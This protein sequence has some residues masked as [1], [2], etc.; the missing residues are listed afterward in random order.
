MTHLQLPGSKETAALHAGK[1]NTFSPEG[2]GWILEYNLGPIG[3]TGG[4]KTLKGAWWSQLCPGNEVL[5][6]FI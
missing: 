5:T 2:V 6:H 1:Y 3:V 4:A